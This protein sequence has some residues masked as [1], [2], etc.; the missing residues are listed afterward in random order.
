MTEKLRLV[1]GTEEGKRRDGQYGR[2]MEGRCSDE[3][4]AELDT[5]IAI[6][7]TTDQLSSRFRNQNTIS[8]QSAF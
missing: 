2:L 3:I 4:H 7:R 1:G 8:F 5:A 6:F